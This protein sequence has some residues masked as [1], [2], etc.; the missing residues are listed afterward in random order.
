MKKYLFVFAVILTALFMTACHQ[1]DGS[2]N[3]AVIE[4]GDIVLA[5]G[6]VVKP[7]SFSRSVTDDCRKKKPIAVV[8]RKQEG[9]TPALCISVNPVQGQSWCINSSAAGYKSLDELYRSNPTNGVDA[10]LKLAEET[11]G[12]SLR[13]D[14]YQ[15]WDYCL[16]YLSGDTSVTEE[17]RSG[18]YLPVRSE[19]ALAANDVVRR[20]LV[21]VN[22]AAFPQTSSTKYWTSEQHGA[23]PQFACAYCLWDNSNPKTYETKDVR[24]PYTL[25]VHVLSL[26]KA[27]VATPVILPEDEDW[28]SKST[29]GV[30]V[31]ITT[32]T[33]D[34]EIYYSKYDGYPGSQKFEKYESSFGF[35]DVTEITIGAIAVKDGMLSNVTRKKYLVTNVN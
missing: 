24:T 19:I 21:L 17:F 16:S 14:Y 22:S 9:T 8:I 6:S 28:S 10:Y 25:P 15:A 5:D 35:G 20:S 18:W 4:V 1:P 11:K 26:D 29:S 13:Y 2:I 12:E 32:E 7:V 34:A 31:S 3:P 30:E 33:E 23:Q 27:T